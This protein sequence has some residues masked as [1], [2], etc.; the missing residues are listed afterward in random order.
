M[1]ENRELHLLPVGINIYPEYYVKE[2]GIC[3]LYDLTEEERKEFEKVLQEGGIKLIISYPLNN[4]A[5]FDVPLEEGINDYFLNPLIEFICNKYKQVYKEEEEGL[6]REDLMIP[7]MFNRKETNGK[8]GI[9]GHVLGD[10][11]INNICLNLDTKE[12]I[13]GV[14]S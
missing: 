11:C 14:D 9:W 5:V 10:L 8:Y 13:L 2:N 7:G 3:F 6:E 4:P 1:K 12:I